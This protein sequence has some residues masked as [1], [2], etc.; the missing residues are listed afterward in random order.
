MKKIL[1]LNLLAA[2]GLFVGATSAFANMGGRV[3]IDNNC[4]GIF[5]TN[6]VLLPG[7]TVLLY[8]CDTMQTVGTATT[9]TNGVF[10][11]VHPGPIGNYQICVVLPSGYSFA[12]FVPAP[13]GPFNCCNSSVNTNG[14]TDCFYWSGSDDFSHNAG[15]CP[16]PTG[17][18]WLTGG[19]TIGG[20]DAHG[21]PL[22]TY[23]GVVNP[24]CSPTAAGGGNWN[25]IDHVAGLHFKGLDIQVI[26]CGNIPGYPAGS[27]SPV[28]PFNYIDFQGVGTLKGID[29]NTNDYG[30]VLFRGRAE[31]HGEPGGGIDRYYLRVY[32]AGGNTLQIIST[33]PANPLDI[34]PVTIS[35]GN[36]QLHISGCNH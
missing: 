15:L 16:L 29:G 10:T 11:F 8:N 24:G 27:S 17:A 4:N 26:T 33:D 31:D 23:G 19:G 22:H 36:M 21:K 28:T 14:C 1:C 18:C 3:W 35:T 12:P 7:V 2:A 25:D 6:D 30:V 34:A 5:E 9:D 13:P 32:D 20:V